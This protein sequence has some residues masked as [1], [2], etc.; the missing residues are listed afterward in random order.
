ME[1]ES[2]IPGGARALVATIVVALV[3]GV[4]AAV[5]PVGALVAAAGLA[6]VGL[7]SLG[8]AMVPL[9]QVSLVTILVGY[10]FLGRGVAHLGVPPIYMGEVVLGIGLIAILV[11]IDRSRLR[12]VHV[13]I[14]AFAAWGA[15]R[16]VPYI[17]T[18]GIDALRDAVTWGYAV[19]AVAVSLTVRPEHFETIIRIYRRLIPIFVFW[20]PVA[21]VLSIGF[22]DLLPR[23]PGSEVPIV[24][25]KGGDMGVQLAGV[26]AFMI[27]GLGGGQ[28][29]GLRDFVIWTGWLLSVVTAGAVNRGGLLAASMVATTVLFLRSTARWFLVVFVGLFLVAVVGLADP[30]IDLGFS[31]RISLDQI[32][33]NVTSIFDSHSN[34]GLEGTKTWR[35]RWWNTIIGYTIDG[36]HFWDGKGYGINLADDDGFQLLADHSLRAPHNGHIEILARSGVP[37]PHA[38]DPPQ[39][40]LRPD[41]AAGRRPGPGGGPPTMGRDRRLDLRLLAGRPG[42]RRV[43][44]LPPGAPG[45]DLVL[46]DD[47]AR[48]R[49]RDRDRQPR[50]GIVAARTGRFSRRRPERTASRSDEPGRPAQDLEHE[51]GH[52]RHVPAPEPAWLPE[53][54]VEPLEAVGLHPARRLRERAGVDVERRADAQQRRRARAAPTWAA[55]QRSCLGVLKARPRRARRRRR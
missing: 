33:A 30:Q 16:T 10:S 22:S 24:F 21:A 14:L 43:R 8:R 54:P 49:G 17:G 51:P 50:H 42:Q 45:R 53:Q 38:L 26:G 44:R 11:S 3:I 48:H 27:L 37:G 9:F 25:F 41:A 2:R 23:A 52:D 18:Y 20:V 7:L 4:A 19:F 35:L 1:G 40:R 55:I 5:S 47:G 32:V 34:E 31:R 39:R 36:P 12:I 46:V 29:V 28:A 6:A 13:A 15:I